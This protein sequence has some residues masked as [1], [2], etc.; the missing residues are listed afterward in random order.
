MSLIQLERVAV[1]EVGVLPGTV[2]MVSTDNLATITTAGYIHPGV[3]DV[4]LSPSDI[5]QCLYDFNVSTGAG[6]YAEFQASQSGGVI[7][8]TITVSPGNVLLPVV[9]G[10]I[11]VFNGVTG[12]I[13]DS[14]VSFTD[15]TKTK[16]VSLNAAPTS[17]HIASFTSANGTIGDGGVLGQAA[18]KAVSD[19]SKATVASVSG[20]VTLNGLAVYADAAGTI[21]DATTNVTLGNSLQVDGNILAGKNTVAGYLASFPAAATSGNLRLIAIANAGNFNVDISNASFAQSSVITI[22]DPGAATGN[23]ILSKTVAGTQTLTGALSF[24]GGGSNIQ[25]TGGG[26]FI[27]GASGAAGFF[28]SYP[29]AATSGRLILEAIN[30]GNFDVTIN[31]ASMGQATVYT[32]PDAGNALGDFL[33]AAGAAPFTSGNFP[34]ASG[35]GGLMIDSGRAA[36]VLLYSSIASP[37]PSIDLVRFDVTVGQADLAAGASK[38][39]YASGGAKQYRIVALWINSGGTN[40]SGGGGDRLG[41][42]TDGTTVYSIIP[43]AT[44]QALVNAGWGIGTDLPFPASAPLNTPT[45]AGASLVMKYNTGTTDY[46]AGSVVISGILERIA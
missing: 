6:T 7:T 32:I 5:I 13:K 45:V 38:V 20:A 8:L 22:P 40:F 1:G 25:T 42:I 29:P 21:G 30:S 11:P 10:N 34:V 43:A 2:K 9:S 14:L 16:V 27:A 18:A 41:E 24:V 12:Q 19:N 28:V 3:T 15:P 44:M 23:F 26:N 36:N 17:G 35:T 4:Q 37:D 39:L 31:N 33:V 46:L